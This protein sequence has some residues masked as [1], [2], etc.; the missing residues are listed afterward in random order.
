[1]RSAAQRGAVACAWI[2][3]RL[4][5]GPPVP[6]R[7]GCGTDVGERRLVR[8]PCRL[9]KGSAMREKLLRIVG[10][11]VVVAALAGLGPGQ[12]AKACTGCN[13][14]CSTGRCCV[15]DDCQKVCIPEFCTLPCAFGT[16]CC[17]VDCVAS[18]IDIDLACPPTT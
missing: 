17:F 10:L 4:R 6:E 3:A 18:C 5:G 9:R 2:G 8:R 15:K 11:G 1:M 7:P 16:H 14:L 12:D 13:I